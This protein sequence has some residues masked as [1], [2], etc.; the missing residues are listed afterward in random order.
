MSMVLRFH[1]FHGVN[2]F[3]VSKVCGVNAFKVS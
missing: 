2:G 3:I 1:R